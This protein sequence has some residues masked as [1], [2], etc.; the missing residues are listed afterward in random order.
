MI[1]C[2]ECKET[3]T[4]RQFKKLRLF[5]MMRVTFNIIHEK[6]FCNKCKNIIEYIIKEKE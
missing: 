5:R 1:K 3:F 6:R 2:N 4:I